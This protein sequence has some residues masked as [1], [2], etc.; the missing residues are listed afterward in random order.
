MRTLASHLSAQDA[1]AFWTAGFVLLLIIAVQTV[2]HPPPPL[3]LPRPSAGTLSTVLAWLI[4][5]AVV[6]VIL[7]TRRG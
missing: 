7:V 5:V 1:Y 6:A 3:R 4:I 2:R